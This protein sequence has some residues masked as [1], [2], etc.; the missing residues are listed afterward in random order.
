MNLIKSL[1]RNDKRWI[2]RKIVQA[3]LGSLIVFVI[4]GL[5]LDQNRYFEV[6]YKNDNYKT[7]KAFSELLSQ[8]FTEL[9]GFEQ[10]TQVLNQIVLSERVIDAALYDNQGIA[11]ARSNNSLSVAD[12]SGLNA[13]GSVGIIPTVTEIRDDN[14][15]PLG[16]LRISFHSQAFQTAQNDILQKQSSNGRLML[17]LA[18][19]AGLLFSR[20]FYRQAND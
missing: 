15:Q 10:A 17:F 14:N 3:C 16:Y 1:Y 2:V 6:S 5:W 7:A 13:Y 12:A 4:V 11:I 19:L 8:R 18:A 9:D 20:A